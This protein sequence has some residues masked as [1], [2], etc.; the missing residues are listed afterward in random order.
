M[1]MKMMLKIMTVL[2]LCIALIQC[3]ELAANKPLVLKKR[4][5]IKL[6]KTDPATFNQKW[7]FRLLYVPR[8]QGKESKIEGLS[9]NKA[10]AYPLKTIKKDNELTMERQGGPH[11]HS[12]LSFPR[13]FAGEGLEEGDCLDY[14]NA[15]L[16]VYTNE[17]GTQPASG[18]VVLITNNQPT[19][20]FNKLMTTKWAVVID[21]DGKCRIEEISDIKKKLPTLTARIKGHLRR[22]L[23]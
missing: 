9:E 7:S 12:F 13:Q 2:M 17:T 23:D 5:K 16:E 20:A 18:S 15:A 22:V 19:D 8:Q 4:V 21:G 1:C 10:Y 3:M 11:C 6:Y 14:Y